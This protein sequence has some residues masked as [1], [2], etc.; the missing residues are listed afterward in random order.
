[1][2]IVLAAILLVGAATGITAA[3]VTGQRT[4]QRHTPGTVQTYPVRQTT[5][6]T[7][8]QVARLVD[9]AV[10]DINTTVQLTQGTAQAAGTGMFISHDGYIVTNNHVVAGSTNIEVTIQG[11]PGRVQAR[12]VGSNPLA[13]I[14]VIKVDVASPVPIV[15]FGNSSA[16]ELDEPVVAIGNALGLGG[17]PTVTSGTISALDRAITATDD[18]GSNEHLS[19]MIQTDAPIEPGNSGGPLVDTTGHV[20]GMNTAAAS[21]DGTRS[22]SLGFALPINRVAR[23]AAQIEAAH[24]GGGVELGLPAFLGIDGQ[25]VDLLKGGPAKSGVDILGVLPGTPAARAGIVPGDIIIGFDGT[26]TPTISSLS[27]LIHRHHPG[28]H[29]LVRIESSSGAET[30]GVQLAPGPAS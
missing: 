1:V 8:A 18:A 21:A 6:L 27:S 28:Q 30:L 4:G 20:V 17:E 14:A 5:H 23:I 15:H 22:T 19:D 12:F 9:P 29:A 26:A 10:V 3:L 13:D 2:L 24:A 25:N 11:R 7:T 16:L